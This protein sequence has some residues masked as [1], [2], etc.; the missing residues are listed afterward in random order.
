MAEQDTRLRAGE[1]R[2]P[3][4]AWSLLSRLRDPRD[5][6]VQEYLNRMIETY[7][8]PVYKYVR[9]AWKR[10]N[11]DAKDLTQAFFVHLLEGDLLAK[12]DPE[13]GN[14]RKLLMAALRNFLSNEARADKAEKRGGGRT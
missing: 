8:R 12:A 14:F 13:R 6:R 4:T 7:W 10:S 9:I 2:F 11:E 3:A 1:S 5:P